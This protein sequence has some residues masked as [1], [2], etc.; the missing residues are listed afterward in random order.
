M[1]NAQ[2]FINWYA[3][4]INTNDLT[5]AKNK[6]FSIRA[7]NPKMYEFLISEFDGSAKKSIKPIK[8]NL[9]K[10]E[11]EE[12]YRSLLK[13]TK[14]PICLTDMASSVNSPDISQIVTRMAVSSSA[15]R[16]I[17]TRMAMFENIPD[18]KERIMTKMASAE[19]I[20]E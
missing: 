15:P 10:Y 1:S 6:L 4:K 8:T 16:R 17:R 7:R 18:N 2:Q 11:D 20:P 14:K 3:N 5:D 9:P 13:M 12:E 19:N